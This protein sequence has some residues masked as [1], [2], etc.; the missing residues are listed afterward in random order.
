MNK[1]LLILYGSESDELKTI[2][3]IKPQ[4]TAIK[5][6]MATPFSTHHTKMMLLNY[7]DGSMRKLQAL[8]T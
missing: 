1:S 3:K 7:K 2:S 6:K 4:V 8:D 5:I